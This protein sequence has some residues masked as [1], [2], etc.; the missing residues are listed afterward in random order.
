MD[1]CIFCKIIKG[2]APKKVY[3]EDEDV[4]AIAAVPA[5]RPVH[6]LVMPKQHITEFIKVEDPKLLEKLFVVAQNMVK[7][8]GLADK[9]YRITTNGGGA[10]YI[11]H[12]HIHV[13]GPLN[14]DAAL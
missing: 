5:S 12:L 6:V 14:K 13:M 2:E 10:Q 3:Y 1:D 7:R 9:G 8:E 11:N 4:L